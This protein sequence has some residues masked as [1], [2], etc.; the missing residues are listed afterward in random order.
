MSPHTH[1]N[2]QPLLMGPSASGHLGQNYC[3]KNIKDN[4]PKS[5]PSSHRCAREFSR[6]YLTRDTATEWRVKEMCECTCLPL[7]QTLGDLVPS[8][9]C[10]SPHWK[11]RFGKDQ[12]AQISVAQLVGHHPMKQK[13]TSSIPGQ[14]TR[15]CAGSVPSW[16]MVASQLCLS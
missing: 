7:S 10:Y 9:Q 6:D 15:L 3:N 16:G 13:V 2:L 11:Q 14:G 4:A 5:I 12:A 1:I 8:K